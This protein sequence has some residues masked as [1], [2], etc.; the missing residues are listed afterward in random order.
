MDRYEGATEAA[1]AALKDCLGR[2]QND[3]FQLFVG[4]K[5]YSPQTA[6]DIVNR[7]LSTTLSSISPLTARVVSRPRVNDVLRMY[8][9]QVCKIVVEDTN[10]TLYI[11]QDF[12]TAY[13]AAL[14]NKKLVTAEYKIEDRLRDQR[15][16]KK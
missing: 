11:P 6:A 1:E 5:F 10:R 8:S 2:T 4:G 9:E 16:Q 3:L 12:P 13:K 15:S 14:N 7:E